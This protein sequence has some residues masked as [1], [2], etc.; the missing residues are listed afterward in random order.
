[1]RLI[2]LNCNWALQYACES[3]QYD[4]ARYADIPSRVAQVDGYLSTTAVAIL[5][6]GRRA[7]DWAK[8]TDPWQTLGEMI[9]RYEAEFSGRLLHGPEDVSRWNAEPADGICWGILGIQGLDFLV[10][11]PAHLDRLPGLFTRGVRVFQMVESGPNLLGGAAVTGDDRGL[12]ELGRSLLHRL[13]E[14]AP[15]GSR[16]GP[17]PVVDLAGLNSRSTAEVLDWFE[18]DPAHRE[19]LLL[20][21]SH[22]AIEARHS[23]GC[24][25]MSLPNLARFRA[26]GGTLGLSVG[27]PFVSSSDELRASLDSVAEIPYLGQSAYAGIGIGTSFLELEQTVVSLENAPKVVDWLTASFPQPIA[28]ELIQGNARKLLHRA[29]GWISGR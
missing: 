1:M 21:R 16:P 10:R 13:A 9:A 7:E 4:P 20:L 22:G 17:L 27:R 6:C 12:T 25:G 19:N 3:S 14:L 24:S 15:P 29:A 28:S 11:E 26:L 8:Q 2:D 5:A 18:G 23:A